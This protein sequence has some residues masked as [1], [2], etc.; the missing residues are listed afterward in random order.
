MDTTT[1]AAPPTARMTPPSMMIVWSSRAAAPVP[2]ITRTCVSA[3]T[4]ASTLT[5]W[6]T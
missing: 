3:T 2:S 6:R 4:G 5:N 1:L